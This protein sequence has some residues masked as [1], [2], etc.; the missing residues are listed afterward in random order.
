MSGDRETRETSVS[1][2]LEYKI[3]YSDDGTLQSTP[4]PRSK[5]LAIALSYHFPE[6]KDMKEKMKA[7]IKVFLRATRKENMDSTMVASAKPA[8]ID[9][10]DNDIERL[11]APNRP[12]LKVLSWD[13]AGKIFKGDRRPTKRRYGR[14]EGAKVAANRGFVCELH[15]KQKSKVSLVWFD[16]FRGAVYN[17]D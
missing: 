17:T 10:Q 5:E 9:C 6:E 1:E 3:S 8:S 7:A 14:M 15:R 2:L 13:P 12:D 11:E 4:P 16:V